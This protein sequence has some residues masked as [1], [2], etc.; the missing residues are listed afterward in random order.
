MRYK[1]NRLWELAGI[2]HRCDLLMEGGDDAGKDE[3]LDD[4]GGDEEGGSDL[5]GGDDDEEGGD[6]GGADEEGGEGE[7]GE[8]EEA[9]EEEDDEVETLTTGEIAKYGLGEVESEIDQVF[10]DIFVK[11]QG[12]AKVRS[13]K[14]IG[15]PGY[16]ELEERRKYSL[17]VLL[18]DQGSKKSEEFD[19]AYFTSEVARYI[20]NYQ[21]LLDIEGMLFSKAKQFILNQRSPEEADNFEELLARD[22]GLNFSSTDVYEEPAAPE[23]VGAKAT[24]A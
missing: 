6:T 15:Y 10:M 1:R 21:S 5:F 11:A 7:E 24:G 23:A 22:H 2:V 17:R 14:S 16:K 8:E 4:A 9:E 13:E 20:N 12:R 18:E 19:M 3:D